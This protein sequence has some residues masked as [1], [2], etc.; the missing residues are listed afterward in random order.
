M[1]VSGPGPDVE[2]LA[3]TDGP[4]LRKF[5]I[6]NYNT[7]FSTVANTVC[8][9]LGCEFYETDDEVKGL[10]PAQFHVFQ[11]NKGWTV[12]NVS[13]KWSEIS[14]SAMRSNIMALGDCAA[15]IRYEM[16]AIE[17]R[18]FELCVSYARQLR[19]R[20]LK[21]EMQKS[22]RFSDLNSAVVVNAIHALFYELC[23]LRDYLAEFIAA[24]IFKIVDPKG[25]AIR[26]M[27]TLQKTL[28]GLQS[29][30]PLGLEILSI[31]HKDPLSPGWLAVL[32]AY[33][34]MF[35]HVAPLEHVS[36]RGFAVQEQHSLPDGQ[37]VPL[38]YYP[39][40]KNIFELSKARSQGVLF[41]RFDEWVEETSQHQP[42]RT[43]EPDALDYLHKCVNSMALLAEQVMLRSPIS[44]T[45]ITITPIQINST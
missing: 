34:D 8:S 2:V 39:L 37:V 12:F 20:A 29:Q 11:L 42:V 38:I 19:T 28:K 33:R 17:H 25:N 6:K 43:N 4:T 7:L 16:K 5:E 1:A 22:Q 45:P 23:V 9:V 35:A 27:N 40:P 21:G 24:H 32:S 41:K 15:R 14:H 44:P 3:G 10:Y 26:K 30:D 18:T 36:I 31:T 13:Q